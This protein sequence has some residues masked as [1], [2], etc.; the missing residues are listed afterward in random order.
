MNPSS[1]MYATQPNCLL[2]LPGAPCDFYL[3]TL[4]PLVV[5]RIN[6]ISLKYVYPKL[7]KSRNLGFV[8]LALWAEF[9]PEGIQK[10]RYGGSVAVFFYFGSQSHPG[11]SHAPLCSP[12]YPTCRDKTP[13]P[14]D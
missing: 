1:L 4:K 5:N 3:Q 14:V 6:V 7:W 8:P 12:V 10:A 2:N 9:C 13:M 11:T